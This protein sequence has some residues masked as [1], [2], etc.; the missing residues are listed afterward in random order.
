MG[1]ARYGSAFSLFF[2]F[3]VVHYAYGHEM[4]PTNVNLV[5]WISLFFYRIA[6]DG[7]L[8]NS[9]KTFLILPSFLSVFLL[10]S[11]GCPPFFLPWWLSDSCD[12]HR[13]SIRMLTPAWF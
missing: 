8:S 12:D 4:I 5:R 2:N 3:Q 6:S 10:Y 1:R 9:M 7:L 13:I 11:C